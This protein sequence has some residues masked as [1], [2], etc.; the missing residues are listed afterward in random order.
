MQKHTA[1]HRCTERKSDEVDDL[2]GRR[3]EKYIVQVL[4]KLGA[5]SNSCLRL[6][7]DSIQNIFTIKN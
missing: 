2:I 5:K 4:L 6:F 7:V 1:V 3:K